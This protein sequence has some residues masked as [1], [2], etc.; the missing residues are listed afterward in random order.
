M[1]VLLVGLG[2]WGEKH[3]RVL[4]ELGAEVWVADVSPERRAAAVAAGVPAARAVEDYRAALARVEAVDIVTPADS[5]LEIA[6]TCL[7]AGR[8]CF[9]E[10]PL[11]VDAGQGRALAEAVRRAGRVLQ[12]GHVF[13]YHPVTEALRQRLPAIGALRYAA[14]RFAGFKRPRTDVGVTHTD[15]IHYFDLFAH[16]L[17][18]PPTAVT[19]TLRDALGRGL[20]D[21]AFITVEYGPVP[22]FVEAGY[23]APGTHRDCTLVGEQATLVG[24]FGTG[25]LRVLAN[26]HV[27]ADGAWKAVEGPVELVKAAGPEPLRA[28]LGAFL[29]AC[30]T[31]GPAPVDVE[32]GRRAV[33]TVEAAWRSSALGR[34]V[35]LSELS[36]RGPEEAP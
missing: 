17:G 25:E 22:V 31:G 3:L 8:H 14:G 33:E 5:H 23:F 11:T 20:D 9:V 6:R 36:G 4:N 12:V 34:R 28:E 10:K 29:D 21:L 32:A 13:R 35:L 2:R 18:R 15:A 27:Q 26:R 1:R 16:L 24:D 7:A 30:R 19:A